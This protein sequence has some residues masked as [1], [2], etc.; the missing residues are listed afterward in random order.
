MFLSADYKGTLKNRD[1]FDTS[2][3]RQ[4]LEVEVGTGRL[5]KSVMDSLPE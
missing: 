4:T 3:G 5:L 1:I 2:H